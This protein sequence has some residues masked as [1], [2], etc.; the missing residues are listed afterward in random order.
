MA[1]FSALLSLLGRKIGSLLQAIFGWS[2]TGLFGKLPSSKQ[3]ALSI[4]M[5]LAIAWPLLVLGVIFPGVASWAFAF[6]PLHE[7]LD[8][9]VLRLVWLGLAL[10]GPIIVGLIT[11]WVAPDRKKKT[12]TLGTILSG[13]PLTIGFFLSFMITLVVVPALKLAAMAK[14][15]TDEH[16]YVQPLEG[17]YR[18]VLHAIRDACRKAGIELVETPMPRSMS[19]ATRVI[20]W[21]ARGGLDPVVADDPR[22]L[23]G[24]DVRLY[25][26]PADLLLRGKKTMVARVRAALARELLHAPAYLTTEEKSQRI[27]DELQRMW[28]VVERHEPGTIGLLARGRVP[29]IA[30]ELDHTDLPFMQWILLYTNLHR[31]ERAV[32]GGPHLVDGPDDTQKTNQPYMGAEI[33]MMNVPVDPRPEAKT[34]D[35]VKEA[36]DE[37]KQLVKIEVQLAKEEVREEVGQAKNAAIMFGASTFMGIVGVALLL[38]ALALAIFPGPIPALVIG[39]VMLVV[40]GVLGLVAYKKVPKKPLDH[41]KQRLETDAKILKERI[42]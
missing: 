13:Y 31:L 15:W 7:M 21:F 39:G 18:T 1:I 8:R 34:T 24:D 10:V 32:C 33:A 41:T 5:V 30:R 28:A 26:Y 11:K 22:K 25:L 3:T 29:E 17:E 38:V 35:L 27:E 4:A 9:N 12:G 6:A 20:K 14:G 36:L 42:A 40:A 37:A 2:I 19:L 23:Q 16:V